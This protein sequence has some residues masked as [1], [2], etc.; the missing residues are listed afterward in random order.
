MMVILAVNFG[1]SAKQRRGPPEEAS[2]G[3]GNNDCRS[4]IGTGRR[5]LPSDSS[6]P[7]PVVLFLI[8]PPESTH[9]NCLKY[10]SCFQGEM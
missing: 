10:F 7:L 1:R 5:I 4:V 6:L 8:F 2:H 3:T 9:F